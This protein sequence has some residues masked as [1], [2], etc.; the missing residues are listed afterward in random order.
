LEGSFEGCPVV[1]EEQGPW[2]HFQGPGGRGGGGG[3]VVEG[4][5]HIRGREEGT[6]FGVLVAT[7]NP[8]QKYAVSS[9]HVFQNSAVS[10]GGR[11]IGRTTI[12]RIAAVE[13][14][15][16][17]QLL[18]LIRVFNLRPTSLVL[19]F[20]KVSRNRSLECK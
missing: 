9:S 6:C 13:H 14:I 2:Y 12:E 18:S 3:G 20:P 16:M 15:S 11:T 8:Q 5:I 17:P 7:N 10:V 4:G 19:A 1:I